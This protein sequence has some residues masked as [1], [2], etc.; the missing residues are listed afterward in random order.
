MIQFLS[1]KPLLFAYLVITTVYT[2]F[3]GKVRYKPLRQLTDHSTFMAPI[4]SFMYLFSA[5]PSTPYVDKSVKDKYFPEL[6]ILKDNWEVIR[7]EAKVLMD[8]GHVRIS[9]KHDDLGFNS[10]YKK[11]W[12]RFYL[13]WYDS[14]IPSAQQLCPKTVELLKNIPS[15]N[16]A[17]FTMLPPGSKLVLHRDPYAGSLRFHMG[18]ITPNSDDC[19][20]SV[21]GIPYSWRD[22][23]DVVFDETYLHT[24][25]NKTNQDR[26]ILFCDLAR[27]MSNGFATAV[28][29]FISNNIMR[30]AATQNQDTDKLGLFNRFF[31][32]IYMIRILGKKIKTA[33]RTFYYA[34]KYTLVAL[35]IYWILF[36]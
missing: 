19:Y 3:R 21:D 12:K 7:E 14:F 35:A 10:F 24:A 5:I 36:K 34:L 16:A 9:T 8:E 13:K 30:H 27:P 15:L 1:I 6:Q 4:N 31:K 29:R 18:I 22:G 20:I 11:G 33:N 23:E 28:N 32:Y 2:H 17:M 25:E 26:L